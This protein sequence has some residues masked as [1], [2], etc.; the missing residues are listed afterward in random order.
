ML[1]WEN[2]TKADFPFS[3]IRGV[4]LECPEAAVVSL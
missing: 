2:L 1:H 4:L 3:E